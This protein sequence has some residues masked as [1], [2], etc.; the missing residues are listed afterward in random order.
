MML[1]TVI[2]LIVLG[3]GARVVEISL[4]A[5]GILGIAGLGSYVA[6]IVLTFRHFDS[7]AGYVLLAV[8]VVAAPVVL[9][10]TFKIFP[11]TFMGKRLILSGGQQRN[12][13]YTS[14]T[15]ERYDELVGMEGVALTRLR[16]SGMVRI[17][18]GKY[19][20]V[21]GGE[22]IDSGET[23]RVSVVEGSRIVVRKV[24]T[25]A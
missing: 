14:Y 19:S 2:A 13:G 4:P 16:P 22:M 11:R 21:T 9:A 7:M 12:E 20:V 3:I 17:G 6:G 8:T 10:L 5:G 1:W 15:S 18:D 24:G 25:E 23:V